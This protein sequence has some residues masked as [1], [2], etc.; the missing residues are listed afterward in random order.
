[1]EG[2]TCRL[3]SAADEGMIRGLNPRAKMEFRHR[4]TEGMEECLA[5]IMMVKEGEE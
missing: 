2:V 4:M 1:Y 3:M 5:D